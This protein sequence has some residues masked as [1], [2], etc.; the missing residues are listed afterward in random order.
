MARETPGMI[1][2]DP[3]GG[4]AGD[5][6]LAG[7]FGLGADPARVARAVRS[8]PGLERFSISADR[9]K[10]GAVMAHRARVRCP[11]TARGRDLAGILRMIDRSPLEPRVRE[12]AA[13]TFRVIG[14][15]EGKIH[16]V[17]PRRVHFH[18]VGAV[19]SIVD[20]VGAA[21]ALSFLGFP[22]LYHRPFRLGGGFVEIAH[23]RLPLPAPA[24]IE[25][26]RGRTV[27]LV[28]E[29]GETVTPTGAA[30]MKALARELS[31]ETSF[32]PRRVVY[33]A[34][35]RTEGAGPG[36]LRLV[37]ADPKTLGRPV[38]VIRTTID[39]MNPQLYPYVQELLFEA[40]ALEAYLTQIVMKKGRPG[41]LLTAICET[42][43]VDALTAVLFRETTTLGARVS[44]ESR[45]EL[46]RWT[47]RVATP[48][49][50]IQVKKARLGDGSVKLAP[51]FES[52]KAAAR[53]RG[54]PL[55]G[56]SEAARAAAA[57]RSTKR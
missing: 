11:R 4:L 28:D 19:D 16:G 41:V 50:A 31:A 54:E 48:Y 34:G 53:A 25:I 24:T 18:E 57:R 1:V 46:E 52:C 5:M 13:A 33:A 36:L 21:V 14:E 44:V 26:L 17:S 15:A 42:D 39:D 55:G 56:V 30:L 23:G 43:A 45:E 32:T 2:V 29:E 7:L 35:T 10:H 8:L 12:L 3:A 22:A 47:E 20:I 27:R 49:G 38:A 40:G 37:A 9:V 6:F 51:E